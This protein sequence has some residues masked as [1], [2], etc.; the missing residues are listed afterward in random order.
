[1]GRDYGLHAAVIADLGSD[2]IGAVYILP[3]LMKFFASRY[4]LFLALALFVTELAFRAGLYEPVASPYSHSG[5]TIT[6][7]SDAAGELVVL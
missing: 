2:R 3:V 6:C 4:L 7:K 1:M 5:T